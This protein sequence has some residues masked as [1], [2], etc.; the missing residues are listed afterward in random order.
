MKRF[1]ILL[2]LCTV[3]LSGCGHGRDIKPTY[4]RVEYRNSSYN[5]DPYNREIA[6]AAG[7]ILDEGHSYDIVETDNGCDVVLHFVKP[8]Q[9]GGG[10]GE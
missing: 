3:F 2:L 4:P 7:Y 1:A 6:V 8:E 5:F 10:N 9:E